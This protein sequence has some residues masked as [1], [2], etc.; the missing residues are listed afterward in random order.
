MPVK[1]IAQNFGLLKFKSGV[2]AKLL[3]VQFTKSDAR[4]S[5]WQVFKFCPFFVKVMFYLAILKYTGLFS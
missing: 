3:V 2:V 1:I 5:Q 4:G